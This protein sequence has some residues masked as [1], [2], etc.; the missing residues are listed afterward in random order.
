MTFLAPGPQVLQH[1][2]MDL[3][4]EL[5]EIIGASV[6]LAG[7]KMWI[8]RKWECRF[9]ARGVEILAE[10]DPVNECRAAEPYP[11][12]ILWNNRRSP[13][14]EQTNRIALLCSYPLSLG[15]FLSLT[16]IGT[17]SRAS[18]CRIAVPQSTHSSILSTTSPTDLPP[19]S[20]RCQL[21]L[22]T[23]ALTAT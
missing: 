4:P 6:S 17:A 23:P 11:F 1:F 5:L 19:P 20:V 14:P 13:P 9:P 18:G 15:Y 12:A 21:R 16:P 2:A 10:Q 8:H 7:H 22:P 3:P